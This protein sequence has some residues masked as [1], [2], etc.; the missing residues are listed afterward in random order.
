MTPTYRRDPLG[1]SA[2]R[3]CLTAGGPDR[4]WPLPRPP[5]LCEMPQP[6]QGRYLSTATTP[7][8]SCITS[9][10]REVKMAV[11][12]SE[13]ERVRRIE[14]PQGQ[15]LLIW[16]YGP[17]HPELFCFVESPRSEWKCLA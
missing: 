13:V 2:R 8:A 1:Q 17:G 12:A 6:V 16:R 10:E 9:H 11:R 4:R 7:P 14:E 15:G 5:S 3:A